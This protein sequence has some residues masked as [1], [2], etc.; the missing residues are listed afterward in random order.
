VEGIIN[1]PISLVDSEYRPYL[2]V[3][4]F[5]IFPI[6]QTVDVFIGFPTLCTVLKPLFLRIIDE[7]T[8]L[9]SREVKHALVSAVNLLPI[10]FERNEY[11]IRY[12]VWRDDPEKYL[13]PEEKEIIEEFMINPNSLSFVASRTLDEHYQDFLD[14]FDKC[15]FP[16]I[17]REGQPHIPVEVLEFKD[18]LRKEGW[19]A[20]QPTS[21]GWQGIRGV[22]IELEWKEELP[23]SIPCNPRPIS[24]MWRVCWIR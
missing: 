18:Y 5:E 1:L 7:G 13:A 6:D 11:E 24:W 2:A 10:E 4:E 12:P 9:Y 19:K 21:K 23:R 16:E 8:E 15:I 17:H 20:F 3:L 14:N 22:E